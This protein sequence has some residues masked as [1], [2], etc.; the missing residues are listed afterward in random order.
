MQER[1]LQESQLQSGTEEV[2]RHFCKWGIFEK[3]S[4]LPFS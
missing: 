1:Q 2:L 3:R 4:G